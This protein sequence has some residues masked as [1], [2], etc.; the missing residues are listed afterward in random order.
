M[1]P[2]GIGKATVEEFAQLGARVL[3]CARDETALNTAKSDWVGKG[4]E[5]ETVIADVADA[6][7]AEGLVEVARKHFG[8][9]FRTALSA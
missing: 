5:I 6:Q 3:T 9:L 7:A 2:A 4:L 1:W 8:G